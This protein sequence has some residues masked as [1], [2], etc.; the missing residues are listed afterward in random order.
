MSH[1]ELVSLGLTNGQAHAAAILPIVDRLLVLF[2]TAMAPADDAADAARLPAQIEQHR[3]ALARATDA[4]GIT[5]VGDAL[6]GVCS[7]AAERLQQERLESRAEI[8][9]LLGLLREA[10]TTIASTRNDF[11]AD[12][13]QSMTRF[14]ALHRMDDLR[15]L[16]MRL[17]S[18]IGHLRQVVDQRESE[19]RKTVSGFEGRVA[20]LEQQLAAVVEIAT[21]DPL[22]DAANR[23]GFEAALKNAIDARQRVV[24]SLF[25][26]DNFKAFNDD[27]GHVAGDG[28]LVGVATAIRTAV[29]QED[30]LGRL[31]GDEFALLMRGVT[32]PQAEVRLR[33]IL[34]ALSA[35]PVEGS[36]RNVTVSCGVA[37]LSAGDTQDSLTRRADQALYDAKRTGKNRVV[38]KSPPFIQDLRARPGDIRAGRAVSTPPR[39]GR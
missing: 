34:P 22:T 27:L 19:W 24:L 8:T 30:V 32:L 33:S 14:D 31:G 7:A 35:I 9:S 16:K 37:E 25:D 17:A 39:S 29:R 28:V 1:A 20:Q 3:L 18:E 38:S 2:S 12:V 13:K 5:A 23:R 36:T 4:A 21:H 26:I 15:Q 10:L 6:H 11:S